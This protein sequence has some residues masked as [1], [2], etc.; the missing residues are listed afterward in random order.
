MHVVWYCTGY[1]FLGYTLV[2]LSL[3]I[4]FAYSPIFLTCN[5]LEHWPNTS[6]NITWT[7]ALQNRWY[8]CIQWTRVL[9]S[10]VRTRQHNSIV[11]VMN[12]RVSGQCLYTIFINYSSM[13]STDPRGIFCVFCSFIYGLHQGFIWFS[14]HDLESFFLN[15]CAYSQSFD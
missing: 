6:E 5:V 9:F 4:Y 8:M 13:L 2:T 3:L 10:V 15:A 7:N 14:F 11:C 1:P 12:S